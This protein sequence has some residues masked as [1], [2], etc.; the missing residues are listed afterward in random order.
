MSRFT[1]RSL[2]LG[3]ISLVKD[4]MK[5]FK[6]VRNVESNKVTLFH[7]IGINLTCLGAGR[8]RFQN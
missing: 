6:A 4:V 3:E 7:I 2:D 8:M 1:N 5:H